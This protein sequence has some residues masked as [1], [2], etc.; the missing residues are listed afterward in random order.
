MILFQEVVYLPE[1]SPFSPVE[2]LN[3]ELRLPYRSE[4]ITRLQ[5]GRTHPVYREGLALL[6]K[7]PIAATQT[8]ALQ[9]E[10]GDP[11]QRIVQFADVTADGGVWPLANVHLSVRDDFALH[12]LGEVLTILRAKD[13]RRILG[14]D[15]NVNHLEQHAS[16]WHDAVLTSTV[17]SY[18]SHP[19][20]HE[21]DDYFLV[22]TE[23]TIDRVQVSG[24]DLSDHEAVTVDLSRALTPGVPAAFWRRPGA[25]A[26]YRRSMATTPRSRRSPSTTAWRSRSSASGC[27][28]SRPRRRRRR[29]SPRSRSATATST[30]PRCTATRRASA[31]PSRESGIPRDQLFVTSKLNNGFHAPEDAL[32]A[33]DV[34]LGTLDIDYVDLFL[35]HWPLPGVGDFVETWKA[36]EQM[37]EGGKVRAI[38]VSNFQQHHLNR[39]LAETDRDPGREPD[40]DPPVPDAGRR[41][42][43]STPSTASRPR[44]GRRSRRARCST[45]P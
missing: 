30:P 21:N 4:A 43:R 13:E 9:H 14:G 33:F 29:R 27:S 5:R 16:L 42:G 19:T 44:R 38:G 8:L 6:S 25:A 12:H 2:L 31:R 11:H 34:T 32:A 40:R 28:R 18:Q 36:M 1:I 10:Q 35:I 15:F 22:P 17:A 3:R 37:Y 24:D 20:S 7:A 41:C 45:T 23:F 39:L 26:P